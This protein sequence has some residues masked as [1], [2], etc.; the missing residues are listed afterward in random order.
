MVITQIPHALLSCIA[1][2]FFQHLALH[3]SYKM[4][5]V[6]SMGELRSWLQT[7][8]LCK[9]TLWLLHV[10]DAQKLA[11]YFQDLDHGALKTLHAYFNEQKLS[12]ARFCCE[13]LLKFSALGSAE[14]SCFNKNACVVSLTR[15]MWTTDFK[16]NWD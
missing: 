14:F 5:M 7:Q 10:A 16:W 6:L 2:C 15:K 12:F 3:S 13:F 11:R 4:T 9:T 1:P 8:C